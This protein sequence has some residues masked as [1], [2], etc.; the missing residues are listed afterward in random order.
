[1]ELNNISFERQKK[2]DLCRYKNKLP[3]DFYL[4][5]LGI[6]I[7]YNGIQH[8]EAIEHFGGENKLKQRKINDKIKKEYCVDNNIPLIIIKYNENV[9]DIL[10]NY[11]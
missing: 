11:L 8:Y 9:E 6:C 2:F 7:E 1:L 5:E 3:F 10:S 4:T